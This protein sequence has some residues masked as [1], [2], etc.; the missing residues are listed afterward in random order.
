MGTSPNPEYDEELQKNSLCFGSVIC[1]K[2][3]LL[4]EL[5]IFGLITIAIN[6]L[7][8]K[9]KKQHSFRVSMLTF[10]A[11]ALVTGGMLTYLSINF[12]GEWLK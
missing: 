12:F 2:K 3:V 4:Y 11:Y 8:I 5:A 6:Y 9:N 10:F 1:Y 7:L